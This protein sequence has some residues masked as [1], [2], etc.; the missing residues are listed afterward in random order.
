MKYRMARKE[1]LLSFGVYPE[2]RPPE[3]RAKAKEARHL[4]RAGTDPGE[5]KKAVKR[6]VV[7]TNASTFEMVARELREA[8]N[9]T[10]AISQYDKTL[11]KNGGLCFPLDG[12]ALYLGD[13]RS[14]NSYCHAPD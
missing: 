3:A 14:R 10:L 7:I 5:K 6:E 1:K 11:I 9:A 13:R 2:V 12:Q 4:I 8:R